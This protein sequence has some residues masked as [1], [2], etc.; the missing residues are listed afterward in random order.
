MDPPRQ[1]DLESNRYRQVSK[2]EMER[3]G[4]KEPQPIFTP[5]APIKLAFLF[6]L[7][8]GIWL[9]RVEF[10]AIFRWLMGLVWR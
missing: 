6:C 9:G 4:V 10:L 8:F 2:Q 3:L 7:F 1:I 5:V